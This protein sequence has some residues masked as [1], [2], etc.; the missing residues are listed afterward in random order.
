MAIHG[1]DGNR[2]SF[3]K[4]DEKIPNPLL[5]ES[6]RRVLGITKP[7]MMDVLKGKEFINGR[8]GPSALYEAYQSVDKK[9]LEEDLL[10]AVRSGR[11]TARD[12]AIKRLNSLKGLEKQGVEA[13]DLF[14]DK[15][16]V[17]PS[18]FR[19][20]SAFGQL[21]LSADANYLYKDLMTARDLHRESKSLFGD[22]AAGEERGALY[23]ALAAVVGLG[24]PIHPKTE[25]K[26]VK[27]F[28]RQLS[29]GGAKHGLFL[30][31]VIGHTVS[32]VGRGVILPD[33]ELDMDTVGLPENIAWKLYSPFTMRRLVKA[34][35][36][37][38]Q[39]ALNIERR[40]DFAKKFLMQEMEQRP[41]LY[42]RAP[43]LHK[44]NVMAA[45]PRLITG[46]AIKISPLV[47]KPFGADF[48]GDQM[49]IH[50]PI[51][52]EAVQEAKEKLLAS[53]NLFDLKQK[54][55]HYT[56]SQEFTLGIWSASTPNNSK[57]PVKFSSSQEAL[58]AYS[59]GEIDIDTPVEIG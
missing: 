37:A 22:E 5:E 19:P 47:V 58:S 25:Q 35:M 18:S 55:V 34:G 29:Q 27:G 8:T 33:S 23:D 1:I 15:V 28:I 43:S 56:P 54:S 32:T 9:K 7:F 14:M 46:D 36:P 21:M 44:F 31:K 17:I 16:P 53:K 24:D 12:T 52:D 49:N 20:T 13:D 41:V 59:R 30:N 26:G 45:F 42:T 3:I 40:S 38:Q 2:W 10:S 6:M 50:L 39:A 57:K 11:K 4:L 48:D 51:S